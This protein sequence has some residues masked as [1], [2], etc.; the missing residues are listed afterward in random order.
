MYASPSCE[1]VLQMDPNDIVGKPFLLFIRADD[2][3]TFV[4]QTDVARTSTVMTHIRLWFQSPSSPHEIPIEAMMFGCADGMVAILRRGRPFIR[5]QMIGSMEHFEFTNSRGMFP[6]SSSLASNTSMSGGSNSSRIE[7]RYEYSSR[8][9]SPVSSIDSSPPNMRVPNIDSNSTDPEGFRLPRIGMR[10]APM[11]SIENIQNLDRDQSRFR[12]LTAV[13]LN[14]QEPRPV[15]RGYQFRE[16]VQI[17]SD[18]DDDAEE[19]SVF[20]ESDDDDTYAGGQGEDEEELLFWDGE[21]DDENHGYSQEMY[22]QME[23]FGV[24]PRSPNI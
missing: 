7:S 4:E 1:A 18:E 20:R 17:D 13:V 14:S 22:E 5:K 12:P 6:L 16:V 9:F 3:G 19:E 10:T 24:V 15:P 8:E 2:L 21:S 11:G 23:T